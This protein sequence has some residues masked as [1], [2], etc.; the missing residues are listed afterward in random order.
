[1]AGKKQGKTFELCDGTVVISKLEQMET[2][3]IYARGCCFVLLRLG[4]YR[5][6]P[7]PEYAEEQP[8]H[9]ELASQRRMLHATCAHGERTRLPTGTVARHNP[10]VKRAK[11]REGGRIF[12]PFLGDGVIFCLLFYLCMEVQGCVDGYCVCGGATGDSW[13]R[14]AVQ[15]R[16]FVP[17]P[18]CDFLLHDLSAT[19][20]TTQG[21]A[22]DA[23]QSEKRRQRC[24]ARR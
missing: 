16:F 11:A 19:A 7:G 23:R 5:R 9:L 3:I 13:D 14:R 17:A 12:V 1:M 2:K 4:W 6:V 24:P 8:Y 15:L 18:D 21:H 22:T 10:I 20:A